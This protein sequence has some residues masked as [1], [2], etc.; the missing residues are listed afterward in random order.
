MNV[1]IPH[2]IMWFNHV[3]QGMSSSDRQSLWLTLCECVLECM[4]DFGN[5]QEG[6][7]GFGKADVLGQMDGARASVVE[8]SWGKAPGL[9][10]YRVRSEGLVSR[11]RAMAEADLWGFGS[12]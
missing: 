2:L 4:G 12:K 8:R 1:N 9:E 7:Y 10:A 5:G 11:A 3:A 6:A